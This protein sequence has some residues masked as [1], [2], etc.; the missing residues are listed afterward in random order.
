VKQL[1]IE[2]LGIGV[3]VVAVFALSHLTVRVLAALMRGI[4]TSYVV[5][6]AAE[7]TTGASAQLG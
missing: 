6:D 7:A 3:A 5:G 4:T 1:G 2:I